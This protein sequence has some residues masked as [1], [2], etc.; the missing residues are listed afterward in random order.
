MHQDVLSELGAP[1]L[2]KSRYWDMKRHRVSEARIADACGASAQAEQYR[3]GRLD[4]IEQRTYLALDTLQEDALHALDTLGQGREQVLVTLRHDPAALAWQL[5]RLDLLR[6]FAAVLSSGLTTDPRWK[7][8]CDL[9]T[10]HLGNHGERAERHVLITD[11]ETDVR[12]GKEM[13]FTTVAVANGIRD[14]SIL[15][16]AGPDRLLERTADLLNSETLRAL[17]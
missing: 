11:T 7:M 9:M 1:H 14:A 4:R 13:G 15:E 6:H 3:A 8:K 5:E 12:S 17:F 2:E 10:A 16:A